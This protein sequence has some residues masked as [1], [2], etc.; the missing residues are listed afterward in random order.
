MILAEV[1][2]NSK[3]HQ[4]RIF[5]TLLQSIYDVVSTCTVNRWS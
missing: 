1:H 3:Q 4:S 2:T 5:S